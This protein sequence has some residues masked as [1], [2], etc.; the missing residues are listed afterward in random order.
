MVRKSGELW[1]SK[2]TPHTLKYSAGGTEYWVNS[3]TTYEAGE[4]IKKGQV[5][6][7]SK[8]GA[9]G[10][11]KVFKASW[12]DD[13]ND[14]IGIALNDALNT[15]E[16]RVLNYGY[17]ELTQA[18]LQNLFIT[19][20]DITV[21]SLLG[22]TEYYTAF[23]S[24][25]VDGGAGNGWSTTLF[26]GNGA[27]IYWYQGRILKTGVSTYV[28]QQPVDGLLTTSTPS[29]YKYPDPSSLGWGD[30]SFN[31]NYEHLPV[32]GNIYQYAYDGAFNITSMIIH[33]NFGKFD[34]KNQF[35]YPA[36]GLYNYDAI[37]DPETITIRHGL[38]TNSNILPHTD[39]AMLGSVDNNIDGP[40]VKV[41][42]GYESTKADSKTDVTIASDTAFYGKV[43]GEINYIL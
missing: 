33:I 20:S 25:S 43:V 22:N 32:I 14:V 1:I 30:D 2:T 34:R 10:A 9:G 41:Y 42:P 28:M 38:F 3:A 19:K 8:S 18:E 23:G 15:Y 31:V 29:G 35:I 11:G 37:P 36:T 13:I 7:I 4:D 39:L 17:L 26:S 6:A 16:V 27:P 40:I 5:L 21:G 24:T 12:P